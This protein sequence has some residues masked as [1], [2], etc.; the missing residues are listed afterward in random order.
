M[1]PTL[2]TGLGRTS[3]RQQLVVGVAIVYL[4]LMVMFVG[5]L[6]T[7]QGTKA[8]EAGANQAS[9]AGESIQT[10]T[11]SVT[12]SAQ[13]AAQIA[14]SSQQELVGVAQVALAMRS[15]SQTSEHNAASA[16]QLEAAARGLNELG[17]KLKE[18]VERYKV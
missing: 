17:Q 9:Q 14:A 1:T 8:V 4:V 16:R 18:L 5:C 10:L 15:I 3:I 11:S 12:E 2:W 7:E 6:A 13:A